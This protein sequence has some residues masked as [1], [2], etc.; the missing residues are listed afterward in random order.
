MKRRNRIK[1][2]TRLARYSLIALFLACSITAQADPA[3]FIYDD[4]GR[5][6]REVDGLGTVSTYT[7]DAV[8]NLLSITRGNI[9][10]FQPTI[11]QI[12]PDF[13]R[14]PSTVQISLNGVNLL[15]G[16]LTTDNPGIIAKVL[17]TT[18]TA[19]VARLEVAAS[20]RLG[21]TI[22][23][24]NNG[25]GQATALM[26]IHAVSSTPFINP[27]QVSVKPQGGTVQMTVG[28]TQVDDF[29]VVLSLTIQDPSI[30]SVSPEQLILPAG[31]ASATV[32][33]TA[34]DAGRTNLTVT[35]GSGEVTAGILSFVVTGPILTQSPLL[36][37][38]VEA[39]PLQPGPIVAPSLSIGLEQVLPPFGP[40]VS[41]NVSVALEATPVQPG[42]IV[43]PNVS[44][45]LEATPTQLGPIVTPLLSIG[46]AP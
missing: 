41:P 14:A 5:L 2:I 7:Y 46:V 8:G 10:D 38:R 25:I 33:I 26:T 27:G 30:A 22:L 34:R 39:P 12:T 24:V 11:T 42:P 13:A 23:T 40:I 17:Q 43:S 31:V 28:V 21:V 35:S 9:A 32:T 29:P 4:L 18:E 6:I 1:K 44:I 3:R 16:Q 37:V 19:I 36:S 15:G 45:T 20:A